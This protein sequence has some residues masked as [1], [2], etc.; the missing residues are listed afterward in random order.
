MSYYRFEVANALRTTL[1]ALTPLPISETMKVASKLHTR[2][3][4]NKHMYS[5]FDKR[6]R[7][8]GPDGVTKLD[9]FEPRLYVLH[10]R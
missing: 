7:E 6:F 10:H 5:L 9:L 3:V 4:K 2:L 1:Q 8:R